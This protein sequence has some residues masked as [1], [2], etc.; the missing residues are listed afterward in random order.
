[1]TSFLWEGG[2]SVLQ[3]N[4]YLFMIFF[5]HKYSEAAGKPHKLEQKQNEKSEK[6]QEGYMCI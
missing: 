6:T 4:I 3:G 5:I 1:M 2:R